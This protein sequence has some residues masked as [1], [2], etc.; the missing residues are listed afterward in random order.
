MEHRSSNLYG[1]P[2]NTIRRRLNGSVDKDCRTPGPKPF[3]GSECEKVVYEAVIDLE[4]MEHCLNRIEILQLAG[5]KNSKGETKV[6]KNVCPS[7]MWPNSF[8][9]RHNLALRQ[10]ENLSFARNTMAT[11]KEKRKK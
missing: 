1:G 3:L 2:F 8:M 7:K 4:E 11:G 5:Q 9:M 6:C 10:S